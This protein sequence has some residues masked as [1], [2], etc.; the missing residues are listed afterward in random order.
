MVVGILIRPNVGLIDG[1]GVGESRPGSVRPI[2]E[3]GVEALLDGFGEGVASSRSAS[4][5]ARRSVAAWRAAM[6][7]VW[8]SLLSV[9]ETAAS[10]RPT[11]PTG[12][13]PTGTMASEVSI[14]TC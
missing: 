9:A 8:S 14:T 3:L 2:G 1:D 11:I 4:K 6:T 7:R 5:L 10:R 13:P 12:H